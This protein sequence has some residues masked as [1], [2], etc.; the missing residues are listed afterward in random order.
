MSLG[1]TYSVFLAGRSWLL[2]AFEAVIYSS[3]VHPRSGRGPCRP[4]HKAEPGRSSS[5]S[6]TSPAQGTS[7]VLGW[8]SVGEEALQ[9]PTEKCPVPCARHGVVFLFSPSADEFIPWED[10]GSA[11]MLLSSAPLKLLLQP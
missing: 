1:V 11:G 6:H 5:L 9:S 8:R 2:A 3:L 4:C 7:H 10:A